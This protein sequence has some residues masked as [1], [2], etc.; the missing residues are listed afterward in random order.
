[1]TEAEFWKKEKR[2]LLISLLFAGAVIAFLAA[3]LRNVWIQGNGEWSQIGTNITMAQVDSVVTAEYRENNG[4][5]TRIE[6]AAWLHDDLHV[7]FGTNPVPVAILD[8]YLDAESNVLKFEQL[9]VEAAYET[10]ENESH[11]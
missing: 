5:G 6:E 3:C 2:S 10:N 9:K 4:K 1:M 11:H 7:H 8:E